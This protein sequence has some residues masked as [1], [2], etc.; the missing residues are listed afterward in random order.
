[1]EER[2]TVDGRASTWPDHR[3][4]ELIGVQIPI[5]QAPMAGANLSEMVVAVSEAGALG[6]LPCALL[7]I[8]Q[9]RTQ[10]ETIRRKTH[11]PINVNFFCHREPR[12][13]AP[14]EARWR[15]RLQ[16]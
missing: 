13:D 6:S 12:V 1:M 9:A 11:R 4:I 5:I 14:R 2:M 7:A 15:Q 10:L 16:R 3:I 8:E